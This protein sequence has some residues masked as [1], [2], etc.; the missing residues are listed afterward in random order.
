M[1]YLLLTGIQ[2]YVSV[3]L[4]LL[5]YIN[6]D[7]TLWVLTPCQYNQMWALGTENKCY[8]QNPGD[9]CITYSLFK[10]WVASVKW[11]QVSLVDTVSG[12]GI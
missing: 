3:S 11:L 8:F 5:L 10:K 4:Q 1:R 9:E 7:E 12:M 6:S 2:C